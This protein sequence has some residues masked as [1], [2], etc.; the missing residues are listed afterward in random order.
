M[1]CQDVQTSNIPEQGGCFII[2]PTILSMIA[3]NGSEKQKKDAER[4][5]QSITSIRGRRLSL[6]TQTILPRQTTLT[7]LLQTQL[8]RLIYD[9]KRGSSLPGE[10][11][12]K[13]GQ[14]PTSDNDVDKAYDYSGDAYR[15]F[16]EVFGRNSIDHNG[17]SLV[18]SVHYVEPGEDFYN[19]A[20]WNG[21]Q[22]I[23]GD[24][25]PSIFKTVLLRTVSAHEM[26]H[27]VVQHEGG[28]RY[29]KDTGA[30][31][32]HFADVFGILAEQLIESQDANHSNWLIG[33]GIWAD[34]VNGEALRSMSNPGTAYDDPLIGKDPQPK[35]MDSYVDLPVDPFNDWGGVH[36]NSGIPNCAF[37][38]AAKYLGGYAWESVGVI[39]YAALKVLPGKPG[40]TTFQNLAN[41]T[42]EIARLLFDGDPK[43]REAVYNA[44]KEVGIEPQILK[45]KEF[46]N[47][48]ISTR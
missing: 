46:V 34:N 4:N 43:K 9:A 12:R 8:D 20:S 10:L 23:Y 28:L 17:M 42:T 32:E 27:G 29:Q 35:H 45:G 30:L 26:G 7:T 31:N 2:P 40:A 36:I 18:S 1:D 48:L 19:N 16:K 41:T 22:M 24:T 14:G 47:L 11:K 3:K 15:L 44:W 13:E 25:D 6:L 5:I 38:K 37:C 33:E 39:W 21:E